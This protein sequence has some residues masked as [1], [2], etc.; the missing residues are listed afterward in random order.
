MNISYK[1]NIQT[2]DSFSEEKI[3]KLKNIQ[4]LMEDFLRSHGLFENG[5]VEISFF[6]TGVASFI[7]LIDHER[8]SQHTKYIFKVPLFVEGQNTETLFLKAWAD[9]GI[10]TP[11]ILETGYLG[12][13]YYIIMEYIAH[14][15]VFE[16]YNNTPEKIFTDHVYEQLGRNLRQMHSP[17]S[18]GF[19][20]VLDGKGT[21]KTLK[22]Y[23]LHD[24]KLRD[25]INY[26][27]EKKMMTYITDLSCNFLDEQF[28]YYTDINTEISCYA[29]NDLSLNNLFLTPEK[30][31]IVFDPN[32][33][34]SHP[35][36]DLA[37]SIVVAA[38]KFDN[39]QP[40]YDQITKGY[41]VEGEVNHD[42]LYSALL[43]AACIKMPYWHRK[44]Y[45]HRVKRLNHFLENW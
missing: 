10:L 43:H 25:N 23:F 21:Y 45:H 24:E 9:V 16:Y 3:E 14:P 29:H 26:I 40:V 27:L 6:K 42:L 18:S 5:N 33:I 13:Y 12:E 41:C 19:G 15:L 17:V 4:I 30:D 39:L 7:C 37:H 44:G 31:F 8:N 32:P 20:K 22:D 28:S 11:T 1:N 35:Y 36:L 38:S 2:R 34:F